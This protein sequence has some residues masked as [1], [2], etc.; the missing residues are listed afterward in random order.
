MIWFLP[1]DDDENHVRHLPWATWTLIL[2]NCLAYLFHSGGGE[3]WVKDWALYAA[4]PHWEDFVTSCFAHFDIEHL[5]GNML[6]LAIFGDNVEDVLGPIPFLAMYFIGGLLGDWWF[7]SANPSMDLPAAGASGCI[8]AAAGAYAVLFFTRFAS[9]RVFFVFLPLGT[10]NLRAPVVLMFYFGLDLV[11]ALAGHGVLPA[12][13]GVNYVAHAGG[14]I[15]GAVAAFV[16][17]LFGVLGRYESW[18][19]GHALFGYCVE[20]PKPRV[21]PRARLR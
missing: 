1:W 8:A 18:T 13:G 12:G 19:G 7:V 6:F 4:H 14:F 2:L 3:Q 17:V 9:L 16:A 5:L 15:T 11:Q 10:I 21:R 20:M